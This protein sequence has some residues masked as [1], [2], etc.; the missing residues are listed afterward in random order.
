MDTGF[1]VLCESCV[2]VGRT[3]DGHQDCDLNP[4]ARSTRIQNAIAQW[5]LRN[6]DRDSE[7]CPS[8]QPRAREGATT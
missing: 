5:L 8:F 3:Q 6:H 2:H 4:H 1:K 7:G